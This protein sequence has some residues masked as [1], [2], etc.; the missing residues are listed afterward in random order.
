MK[1]NNVYE[2]PFGTE[3]VITDE[4]PKI[5]A[6]VLQPNNSK[7]RILAEQNHLIRLRKAINSGE[8]IQSSP[9]DNIQTKRYLKNGNVTIDSFKKYARQFDVHIDVLSES[10]GAFEKRM[11]EVEQKWGIKFKRDVEEQNS[12][13][14]EPSELPKNTSPDQIP[15]SFEERRTNYDINKLTGCQKLIFKL[16]DSDIVKNYGFN[17]TAKE[18]GKVINKDLGVRTKPYQQQTISN[19]LSELRK[20]NLI[21]G[22]AA[23]K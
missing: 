21:P 17:V 19:A 23:G 16:W 2:F 6:Q 7:E 8:L 1:T 14:V 10:W 15:N 9:L 3:Q 11:N 18:V 13:S 12:T 4:I 22:Y 20:K 5:I